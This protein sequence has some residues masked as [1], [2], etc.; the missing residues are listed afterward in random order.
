MVKSANTLFLYLQTSLVKCTRNLLVSIS[1]IDIPDDSNRLRPHKQK[2][3]CYS[4]V[5]NYE[6]VNHCVPLLFLLASSSTS[7]V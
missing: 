6:H 1:L 7:F 3:N 5:E 2:L 4:R